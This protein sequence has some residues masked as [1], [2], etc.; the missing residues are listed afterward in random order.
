M[1]GFAV[2]QLLG[3]PLGEVDR[4]GETD[5]F[6]SAAVGGNRGVDA[7][8]FAVEVHQRT[9]AVAGVDR[10]IGLDEALAL[11]ESD[12]A[13]LGADDS[14]GHGAFQSER[15]AQGQHPI[16]DFHFIAVAQLR[17]REVVGALDAQHGQVGLRVRVDLGGLV[18]AAVVQANRDLAAVANNV[19]VGEDHARGIDN[20]PGA[21]AAL[22]V[23]R[24]PRHILEE[25]PQFRHVAER[26]ERVVIV[27]HLSFQLDGQG[28]LA[29]DHD[30][31]RLNGLDRLAETLRQRPCGGCGL[32]LV[33]IGH[34][35]ANACQRCREHQ[36]AQHRHD[37]SKWS[38]IP[39]ITFQKTHCNHLSDR[40]AARHAPRR[41]GR[42]RP[43]VG[44]NGKKAAL[45]AAARTAPAASTINAARQD[46]KARRARLCVIPE[47][48]G[49]PRSVTHIPRLRLGLPW[50]LA[51]RVSYDRGQHKAQLVP[52]HARQAEQ[53]ANT[54]KSPAE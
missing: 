32:I 4:D 17:G 40:S 53:A 10:G 47:G 3:D 31:R 9:A 8:D 50:P 12:S 36:P 15:I 2:G 51:K 49:F 25:L 29:L 39:H 45:T 27:R 48:V 20:Q 34:D 41:L 5:T 35:R 24:N 19:G 43:Q 1:N 30:H 21:Q 44:T 18:L 13:P 38:P 54:E 46:I 16:A 7:D 26:P 6:V 52:N 42:R 33:R 11:V 22:A 14:R 23:A 37:D 28:R